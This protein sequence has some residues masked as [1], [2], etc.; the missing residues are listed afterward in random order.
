MVSVI[1]LKKAVSKVGSP[2]ENVKQ[3]P[4]DKARHPHIEN[5]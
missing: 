2:L 1:Q 3:F 5:N 4:K